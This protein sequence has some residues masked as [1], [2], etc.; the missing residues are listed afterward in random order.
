V[1]LRRAARLGVVSLRVLWLFAVV[2]AGLRVTDLRT[3]CRRLGIHLGGTPTGD[4][5]RPRRL[6][7][8][9]AS[10]ALTI[11]RHVS[12][13]W[14]WGDTCLRRCLVVGALLEREQP[15]LVIGVKKSESGDFGAHAWL[16][17]GGVSIDRLSTEFSPISQ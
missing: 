10:D 17:F 1:R 13:R 4:G 16:E 2:E 3:L 11:V 12:R 15:T 5:D 14:P 9:A 6:S 8:R 7:R